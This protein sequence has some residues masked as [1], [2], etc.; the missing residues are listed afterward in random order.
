MWGGSGFQLKGHGLFHHGF[1]YQ[2]V[3][4]FGVGR[5]GGG[6]LGSAYSHQF[7]GGI[8]L[9]VGLK[10]LKVIHGRPKSIKPDNPDGS[11]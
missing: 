6:T 7:S 5:N 8:P 11:V 4:G 1:S 9:G 2:G 10:N 3:G